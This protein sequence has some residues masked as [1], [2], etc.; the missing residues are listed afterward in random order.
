LRYSPAGYPIVAIASDKIQIREPLVGMKRLPRVMNGPDG[1]TTLKA[2]LLRVQLNAM[3][4]ALQKFGG[5]RT[6]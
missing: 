1:L 2:R 3:G 5:N 4:V 6:V